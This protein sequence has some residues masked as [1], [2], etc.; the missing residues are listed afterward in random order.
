MEDE[1]REM[2]LEK[3]AAADCPACH[4]NDWGYVLP[5]YGRLALE[6]FGHES[7]T[8]AACV[9]QHCGFLKFHHFQTLMGQEPPPAVSADEDDD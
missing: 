7:M 3:G 4:Q 1:V 5:G 2:L 6:S 9:C 8:V